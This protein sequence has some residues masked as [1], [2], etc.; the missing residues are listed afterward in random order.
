M[1]TY[2]DQKLC[3]EERDNKLEIVVQQEMIE[4]KIYI[5]RRHKVM[6]SIDLAELYEVEPIQSL[7]SPLGAR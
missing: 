6:L 1:P 2:S 4:G 5:I 7:G 3:E